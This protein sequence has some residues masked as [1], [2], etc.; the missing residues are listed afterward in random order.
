MF[1]DFIFDPVCPWCFIGK[2][3][4]NQACALRPG[5]VP[6]IRWR[7]FMLNPEM[8]DE[9]M[10]RTAY[11]IK[12]FGSEARVRR[13]Y[14]SLN[15]AGRS[16]EAGFDFE[17]IRLTPNTMNAHRLIHYAAGSGKAE[18]MLDALFHGYF[19]NVMDI[20]NIGVLT[21]IGKSIGFSARALADYLNGLEGVEDVL[22]DNAKVHRL[23]VNSVPSFAFNGHMLIAGAQEPKVLAR[24]LDAA[25]AE[26]EAA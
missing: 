6:E 1:I 24:L 26:E 23:G 7:H 22:E 15:E 11:L 19:I 10:D 20:G 5:T 4:L 17:R 13:F 2:R 16:V 18:E 25:K 12:K 21:D 3:R 14:G 8:P 9:G